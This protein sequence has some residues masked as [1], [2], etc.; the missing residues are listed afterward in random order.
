[1]ICHS[2]NRLLG[3]VLIFVFAGLV[4]A[5]Q[6]NPLRRPSSPRPT[7]NIVLA[8]SAVKERNVRAHMEFLASD[9]LQGR[10]SATQYELIAGEYIASQLHQFGIEP[11]GDSGASGKRSFLQKVIVEKQ[12]LK[13][14]NVVGELRGRDRRLA[15]GVVVLSAHMDHLG[16][17]PSDTGDTIYN[18]ADD[19]A[20]GVT[21]VLELARALGTGPRP[22]RTVYFVLFGSEESGGYGAHFFVDNLRFP[23]ADI[24]ANLEFEMIGRPDA[25]V[26]AN[27]LWLTGYD[28]SNLGDALAKRGAF[29][30]PDPHPEENFFRRSDNYALARRGIVAHTVSSFGLH[31]Q[32]HQPDDEL[33]YIDFVHMTRAINSMIRPVR[34]LVNSDFQPHWFE[35]KKP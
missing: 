30:L 31:P 9:A 35:G 18:G 1:M 29:L 13:T 20:S 8:T 6:I 10:G 21:A 22:R 32:Y 2:Q 23:L 4:A 5:Q 19:D 12:Q 11:A 28:R 34:W 15:K 24:V 25:K 26:P 14:W 16:I 33:R 3:A 7:A 27:A 17:R